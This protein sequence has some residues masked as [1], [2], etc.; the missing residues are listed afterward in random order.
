MK[1]KLEDSTLTTHAEHGDQE[2]MD[3]D[4]SETPH[5]VGDELLDKDY[6]AQAA[7]LINQPGK[8]DKYIKVK[9]GRIYA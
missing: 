5:N 4:T 2:E 7:S 9:I 8:M 6:R 3:D 1:D